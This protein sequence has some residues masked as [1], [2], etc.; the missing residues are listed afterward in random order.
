MKL[1]TEVNG[2]PIVEARSSGAAIGVTDLVRR[3]DGGMRGYI[4]VRTSF[5]DQVTPDSALG[6]LTYQMRK[7]TAPS[8]A[9]RSRR[10]RSRSTRNTR[11]AS[12]RSASSSPMRSATSSAPM[13]PS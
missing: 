5:A 11:T 1:A 13:S 8:P 10:W 7:Q 12:T 4:D 2:I 3:P 6:E 9:A